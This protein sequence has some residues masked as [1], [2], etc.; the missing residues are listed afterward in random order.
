MRGLIFKILFV[1]L[2]FLISPQISLAE[3]CVVSKIAV[4]EGSWEN[5]STKT[6][7]TLQTQDNNG[8]SCH[9]N[10]TLRFSL[11]SSGSG[12]FTSQ[13]GGT[14]QLFIS[15][16]TSNRNFYY[17]GHPENYTLTANVGY[18]GANDWTT[19]FTD[20]YAVGSSAEPE[21]E[22]SSA[23]SN[24]TDY[25]DAWLTASKSKDKFEVS[26]GRDKTGVVG[27]PIE[28]KAE[29]N[30][31]YA[32]NNFFQWNFGDGEV[33]YGPAVT[34]TYLYPGDYTVVLN[35]T[36][37][38]DMDA[39]ARLSVKIT[40]P[41]L[42]VTVASP[43]RIEITN[44]GK[45]EANLFGRALV[46]GDRTFLF[47][48]GTII[49]AGQSISFGSKVTGLTPTVPAAVHIFA[50]GTTEHPEIPKR[51]EEE[52]SKEVARLNSELESNLATLEAQLAASQVA[53]YSG[54]TAV[55]KNLKVEPPS[56]ET[57][58]PEPEEIEVAETQ[59]AVAVKSGWFDILKRFFLR[60]R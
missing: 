31:G 53:H 21:A 7:Y 51:I 26:A 5:T 59:T 52:K 37:S 23:S 3:H 47:P 36:F 35:V 43:E 25:S 49:K 50:P 29:V 34:H 45:S 28:F 48:K 57:Q 6:S 10:Q 1:F 44:A 11:E 27:S 41:K 2:V 54:E 14:L 33:A 55:A 42:S 60:T 39:T 18:G 58:L 13:S 30:F 20:T 16:G 4:I 17:D 22:S 40:D 38:E 12:T 56:E 15:S 46:V 9:T 19:S 8:S 24:S 32:K